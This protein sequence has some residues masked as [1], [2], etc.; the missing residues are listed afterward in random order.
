MRE[1]GLRAEESAAIEGCGSQ[2]DFAALGPRPGRSGVLSVDC[3][4]LFPASAWSIFMAH[5]WIRP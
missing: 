1:G 2:E 5:G 3:R 4:G